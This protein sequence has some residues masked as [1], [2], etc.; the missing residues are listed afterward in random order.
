L[1]FDRLWLSALDQPS[2]G[3]ILG[4]LGVL[5]AIAVFCVWLVAAITFGVIAIIRKRK[6]AKQAASAAPPPPAGFS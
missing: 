6:K 1:A 2:G 5:L 4:L 3:L